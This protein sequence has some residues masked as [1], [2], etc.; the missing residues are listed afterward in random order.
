MPLIGRDIIGITLERSERPG[1]KAK[2]KYEGP[3]AAPVSAGQQLGE[4]EITL[5]GKPATTVPLVAAIDVPRAGIV[6]RMTGALNY[7]IWGQD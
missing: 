3:I 1:L 4:V 5:D 6:G 7:L 2:V